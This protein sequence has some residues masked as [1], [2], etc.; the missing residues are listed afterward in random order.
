VPCELKVSP[1]RTKDRR[2][3]CGKGGKYYLVRGGV[4]SLALFLCAR[5]ARRL[6]KSLEIREASPLEVA[7]MKANAEAFS[8]FCRCVRDPFT[9]PVEAHAIQ[10]RQKAIRF[11]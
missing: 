6:E 3:I 11:A 2:S 9:C 8:S 7:G 10:A 4:G 5:H 1:E